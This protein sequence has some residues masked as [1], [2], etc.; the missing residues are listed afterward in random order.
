MT[1]E[2]R[3]RRTLVPRFDGRQLGVPFQEEIPLGT[4]QGELPRDLGYVLAG[5]QGGGE[6]HHVH[7]DP[8]GHAQQ[9]VF[10]DRHELALLN[11]GYTVI[12]GLDEAGRGAWAGPVV[13]GAVI[14]PR[15][16]ARLA[17]ISC[18]ERRLAAAGLAAG[19]YNPRAAPFQ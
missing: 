1:S 6:D 7:R 18:V 4:A 19:E 13:A 12:A 15:D 11:K 8:A 14:L 2:G 5:H 17:P 9:G 3:K 10:A 16:L